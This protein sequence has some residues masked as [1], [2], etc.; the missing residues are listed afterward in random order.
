MKLSAFCAALSVAIVGFSVHGSARCGDADAVDR[1]VD[2]RDGDDAND[3]SSPGSAWRTLTHAAAAL[4]AP[5]AATYALHVAPGVYSPSSGEDFPLQIPAHVRLI[6]A[7]GVE[8]RGP[9]SSLLMFLSTD[10]EPL[11]PW[12]GAE[13]LRL[14][15]ADSGVL[16][17]A[18]SGVG[19]PLF[20][21]L[22]I[23]GMSQ[24][25]VRVT[26]SP[27]EAWSAAVNPVFERVRI[28]DCGRGLWVRTYGDQLSSS[29]SAVTLRDSTLEHCSLH[30]AESSSGATSK[31]F[32]VLTRCIVRDNGGDGLRC[33]SLSNFNTPK[34]IDA[35]A[36]LIVGNA[37][38]GMFGQLAAGAPGDSTV[39][40]RDCTIAG[41][42]E[43]GIRAL[44]QCFATIENT[45]LAGN[46]TD[47]DCEHAPAALTSL[48]ADGALGGFPGCLRGDPGFVDADGGD[49]ALRWGS[50]CI[51]RA[52]QPAAA[53]TDLWG[54]T[55]GV[56]GDLDTSGAPDIGAFEFT[57]L[58]ID[59]D[60]RLG[61]FV[62]LEARGPVQSRAK[63]LLARAP[64]ASSQ[65]TPFGAFW[66]QRPSTLAWLVLPL[67]PRPAV[68]T[69]EI[70]ADPSLV[71]QPFSIQALIESP[72]APQGFALS[73]PVERL[74]EP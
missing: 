62:R 26:S 40:A 15:S 61:G 14:A 18:W 4:S 72:L 25:G 30:G 56:D 20:R 23:E 59:G 24:D 43:A 22:V 1:Y 21:D 16:V 67:A 29:F 17:G 55:R 44:G 11:T 53:R 9:S 27:Y 8:L 66:L 50:R 64:L 34:N 54:A 45:L 33:G 5:D 37:G 35:E 71:G 41:N 47:V 38:C 13:H 74:I 6:G 2:L 57:T 58:S 68:L 36:C 60:V 7:P 32:L 39:R 65:A 31:A 49:F 42:G 52:T 3:G 69:R 51:D 48:A 10:A 70:P 46:G 19:A 12:S 63:L 28:S 73:N